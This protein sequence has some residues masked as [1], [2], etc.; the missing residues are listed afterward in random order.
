MNYPSRIL[1]ILISLFPAVSV[2]LEVGFESSLFA[3]IS[4]T[5]NRAP[6]R[7]GTG[8]N[9]TL[10]TFNFSLFGQEK[11]NRAEGG[12]SAEFRGERV[13]DEESD[14][15]NANETFTRFYGGLSVATP[16]RFLD[17]Y[18]GDVLAGVLAEDQLQSLDDNEGRQVNVFITGP[19][20]STQVGVQKTLDM[21]FYYVNQ[22]DDTENDLDTLY[23]LNADFTSVLSGGKLWGIRLNDVYTDKPDTAVNSEDF[24]R[25]SGAVF[26]SRQRGVTTLDVELGATQYS[27][28]GEDTDGLRFGLDWGRTLSNTQTLSFSLSHDLIDQTLGILQDLTT[29]QQ[30]REE[31]NGV[32]ANTQVDIRYESI[33][34][35]NSLFLGLGAINSDFQLASD[36]S[37]FTSRNTRLRDNLSYGLRAGF[38]RNLSARTSVNLDASLQRQ[39][40]LNRPDEID[41]LSVTGAF[42]FAI[43]NRWAVELGAGYLQEEGSTTTIN[44][45]SGTLT[46]ELALDEIETRV[47]L[48]LRWAPPTRASRD[49]GGVVRSFL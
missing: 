17:W 44:E 18:F 32:A 16:A 41:S 39:E 15:G 10:G 26:V 37:G 29:D 8:L 33:V 2:A 28:N 9:G 11:S 43:N 24:N 4:D 46:P 49:A 40:Y 6:E 19:E 22:S 21:S 5:D 3:E 47:F 1:A 20:I 34:G 12:F 30:A 35:E 31:T 23:R 7:N 38:S 36:E 45:I 48:G 42:T 27:S 14:S 25:A 13:L